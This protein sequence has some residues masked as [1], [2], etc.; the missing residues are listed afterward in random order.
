MGCSL[1]N[2]VA[3]VSGVPGEEIK[4]SRRLHR[5]VPLKVQDGAP[6]ARYQILLERRISIAFWRWMVLGS[7]FALE[8]RAHHELR[9][10]RFQFE[11]CWFDRPPSSLFL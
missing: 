11:P 2:T 3:E 5:G 4:Y 7:S 10:R 1:S 9:L 6:M 8:L